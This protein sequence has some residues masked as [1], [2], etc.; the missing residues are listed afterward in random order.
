MR[1]VAGK[2]N[3]FAK[4]REIRIVVMVDSIVPRGTVVMAIVE[5]LLNARVM[6]VSKRG[7]REHQVL[8]HKPTCAD[9]PVPKVL[10]EEITDRV[11]A[12]SGVA[13]DQKPRKSNIAYSADDR[14]P[15]KRNSANS[16]SQSIGVKPSKR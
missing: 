3:C 13:D 1:V 4:A 7:M 16:S 11:L 5:T 14:K 12:V 10:L 9:E 15:G 2:E 6:L 8:S